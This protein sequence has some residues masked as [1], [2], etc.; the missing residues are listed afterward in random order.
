M[1]SSIEADYIPRWLVYI[2]CQI[3]HADIIMSSTYAGDICIF[4]ETDRGDFAQKISSILYD[5]CI[6]PFKEK[7]E[8][9]RI[10]L[11][12]DKKQRIVQYTN[13]PT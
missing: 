2:I 9:T 1:C 13:C 12:L 5:N 7:A 8:A 4:N 10:W 3:K 6:K 11:P